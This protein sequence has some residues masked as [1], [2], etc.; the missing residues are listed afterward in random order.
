[1]DVEKAVKNIFRDLPSEATPRASWP[2]ANPF[3]QTAIENKCFEDGATIHFDRLSPLQ[4]WAPMFGVDMAKRSNFII[5][6]TVRIAVQSNLRLSQSEI[7]AISQTSA[8]NYNR[9]AWAIPMASTITAAIVY[10]NRTNFRFPFY[11]PNPDTW[12]SPSSFPTR[13]V[14]FLKG[15]SAVATW[16]AL[17]FLAYFQLVKTGTG[18]FYASIIRMSI[19]ADTVSDQRMARVNDAI[20]RLVDPKGARRRPRPEFASQ[21]PQRQPPDLSDAERRDDTYRRVGLP[22]PSPEEVR[23]MGQQRQQSQ[24]WQSQES[25]APAEWGYTESQQPAQSAEPSS[26]QTRQADQ[27]SSWTDA[28]LFEDDDASPVAAA[29][30]RTEREG[31]PEP[32]GR[33]SA[34]DRLRQQAKPGDSP[35][36]KRDGSGQ[37]TSWSRLRQDA[38]STVKDKDQTLPR[39]SYSYNEADE[40]KDYAKSQAQKEFDAMLEAERKGTGE[41]GGNWK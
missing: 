8:K 27:S 18:L 22:P 11:T 2:A 23:R 36:A 3:K 21:E 7:D 9:S 15:T 37:G 4:S 30:R 1:M 5:S 25:T 41:S 12:F 34:W 35:S 20:M 17:R 26:Q 40:A 28:G 32:V 29:A 16:H 13:R 38:A 33:A 24:P 19:A 14:S 39:D 6:N 31:R 10:N